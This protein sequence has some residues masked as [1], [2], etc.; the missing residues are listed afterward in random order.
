MGIGQS[1]HKPMTASKPL[2]AFAPAKINLSL[3]ILGR[4]DD[5]YHNLESLVVFADVGDTL[6]AVPADN[7]SL[8]VDGPFASALKGIPAADNLVLKAGRA[9][10][11]APMAFHLTK[12]LPIAAGLGGG[13]TDAAAAIRMLA[14]PTAE[15]ITIATGL[16]ADVP[17]CL[18]RQPLWA[19]GIGGALAPATL[20]LPLHIVLVNANVPVATVD[21]FGA[22]ARPKRNPIKRPSSFG[23][24]DTL[25]AF[26]NTC[27]ND[28][29]VAAIAQAPV[30]QEVMNA[31]DAQD[32]CGLARLS[33]SGATC[34]GLFATQAD[35]GAAALALKAAHENW[36]VVA[37]NTM[38]ADA[39]DQ[40]ARL[41]QNSIKS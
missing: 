34:F 9:V 23:G 39:D 4:R 19:S 20:P 14:T 27:D 3:H 8:T 31:L 16:G 28:L 32:G 33:G 22:L 12:N 41:M 17:M 18:V 26:L 24:F 10:Q 2:R 25:L 35:A 7:W 13:S 21:V 38:P 37:T 1:L 29:T 5:G 15:A 40:W 11:D 30:I 6:S 36:W